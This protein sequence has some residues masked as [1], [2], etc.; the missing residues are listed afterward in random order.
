MF[1]VIAFDASVEDVPLDMALGRVVAADVHARLDIPN[2]TVSQHDGIAIR[3]TL[4]EC[5]RQ[6]RGFLRQ[7]EYGV[8][9][10]GDVIREGFDTIVPDELCR[11]FSDGNVELSMLPE[12]GSGVVAKG[13]SIRKGER[14]L[15]PGH[16]LTPAN[17]SILR[18]SGVEQVMVYRKPL[19]SI[20]PI[21]TDC[22][23]P[24]TELQPGEMIESN[25]IL[26]SSMV[27]E[28]GGTA[29]VL[30]PVAD[31]A[32]L[33]RDTVLSNIAHC[34]LLITIGGI[35][36]RGKR[37]GD[38]VPSALETIGRIILQ[39][40]Q[41]APGGKNLLFAKVQG[42]CVFGIPGAPH[43]AL[44]VTEQFLPAIMEQFLHYPC[45][46]RPE[47][48]VVLGADFPAHSA[49]PYLARS[50]LHWNGADYIMTPLRPGDTA[51]CFINSCA[52]ATLSSGNEHCH[53]GD[54][55]RV[56]LIY[57]ERAIRAETKSNQGTEP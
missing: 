48:E 16:R 50:A 34:N 35:G 9:G 5:V 45:W 33:I 38:M 12:Y 8:V 43:G 32:D 21:G 46:E 31:D 49:T 15:A 54:R 44:M 14:M 18:L 40:V 24:G 36:I 23:M 27:Q 57:G 47:I 55:M 11:F 7:Q 56:S 1:Q 42:K 39:G 13:S 37:Y 3:R 30:P 19:V 29:K 2:A 52:V 17:L 51:D 26:I 10:M 41:I 53:K 20:L 4:A 22:R 6:G 25:S 28:C